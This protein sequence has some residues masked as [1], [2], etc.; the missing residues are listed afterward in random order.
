MYRGRLIF[1]A[2]LALV[3]ASAQAA[4]LVNSDFTLTDQTRLP[5]A[6]QTNYSAGLDLNPTITGVPIV[7]KLTENLAGQAGSAW[8]VQEFEVPSFTMWAD[9]NVD[10]KPGAPG[11]DA[12]CPADGFTM[13]FAQVAPTAI[14]GGGGSLGLYGAE[15][16][17]PR[18]I[19][20]EV[21]TWKDNAIED[22]GDCSTNK[23][24]TFGFANANADTGFDRGT[25][26]T[27]DKGGAKI[28]Q[29]TSPVQIVNGGWYRYQWN[30]DTAA[31]TMAIY[32]TG[33]DEANK[34]TQNQKVAEITFATG[35]PAMNFKG[36]FG[37]TAATG[38]ATQGTYIRQVRIDSPMIAAGEPPAVTPPA[39]GQ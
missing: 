32:L 23:N 14:G 29:V 37:L 7:L 19:A 21:N 39:A 6:W 38:G 12:T 18:F 1:A 13:A 30:V 28:G 4:T 26:G 36:R 15:A 34:T 35:A 8:T 3:T 31:R 10:F 22:V 11:T 33:L 16:I 9:I 24:V 20:L 17:V 25:A 5:T 2:A 27:P